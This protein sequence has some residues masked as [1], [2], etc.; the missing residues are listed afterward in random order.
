MELYIHGW[1]SS[2]AL[3]LTDFLTDSSEPRSSQLGSFQRA[4]TC[5]ANGHVTNATQSSIL[6]G[7]FAAAV[8]PLHRLP[9]S[10][11]YTLPSH[12]KHKQLL[13]VNLAVSCCCIWVH[14]TSMSMQSV[15]FPK[16]CQQAAFGNLCDCAVVCLEPGQP[17]S[18]IY[19]PRLH[20]RKENR[21]KTHKGISGLLHVGFHQLYE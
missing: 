1:T 18:R 6:S 12:L 11:S 14:D 20:G 2:E 10:P 5:N 21:A 19:W 17:R 7:F 4:S 9:H 16:T 8:C 15:T 3:R 13:S